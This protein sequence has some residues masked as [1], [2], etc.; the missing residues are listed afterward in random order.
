VLGSSNDRGDV[1][2]HGAPWPPGHPAPSYSGALHGR[3]HLPR[4]EPL[5]EI[6]QIVAGKYRILRLLGQGGMGRCSRHI[7]SSS[8]K[9]LP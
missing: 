6:G 3:L 9:R 1:T 5:P 7:T 8:S 2:R 4:A